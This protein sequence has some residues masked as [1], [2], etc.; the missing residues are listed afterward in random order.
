[1][2]LAVT[3]T[4]ASLGTEALKF[5]T[6]DGAFAAELK[7]TLDGRKADKANLFSAAEETS[8]ELEPDAPPAGDDKVSLKALFAGLGE[9]FGHKAPPAATSTA[10]PP[11]APAAGAPAFDEAAFTRVTEGMATQFAAAIEAA[12]K[13]VREELAAF[14]A[15]VE[16]TDV[17]GTQR[18]AS[19]GA[20]G[21]HAAV[22]Y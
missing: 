22:D 14:K 1:M 15:Q 11:T 19:P 9:L 20:A 13:P 6:G 3:D 18:P 12:V 10:V 8:I 21:F 2:G 17:G 5:S 7:S 16:R 4:P